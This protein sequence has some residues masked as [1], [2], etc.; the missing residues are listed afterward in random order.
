[1]LDAN[2]DWTIG[3]LDQVDITRSPEVEAAALRDK[4]PLLEQSLQEAKKWVAGALAP[5]PAWHPADDTWDDQIYFT[6]AYNEAGYEKKSVALR[7]AETEFQTLI[8]SGDPGRDLSGY[9]LTRIHVHLKASGYATSE[10]RIQSRPV[11]AGVPLA[12]LLWEARNQDQHYNEPGDLRRPILE[13]FAALAEHHSSIFSLSQAPDQT[14]LR[15]L[16]K[17]RSWAPEVLR[18]LGWTSRA[19]VAAGLASL[20]SKKEPG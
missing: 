15:G 9:V 6:R 5:V 16:V 3:L 10:A 11:V 2:Q 17:Q 19:S 4:I 7:E 20:A 12:K 14:T 1:M 13:V 8:R 18:I